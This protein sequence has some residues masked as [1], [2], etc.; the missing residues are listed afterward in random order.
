MAQ[1]KRPPIRVFLFQV[2]QVDIGH[3]PMPPADVT[4]HFGQFPARD[5]LLRYRRFHLFRRGQVGFP[6]LAGSI[7]RFVPH[8]IGERETASDSNGKDAFGCIKRFLQQAE[9]QLL[10]C[11]AYDLR[12]LGPGRLTEASLRQAPEQGRGRLVS[13]PLES[14][15]PCRLEGIH[16]ASLIREGCRG[17]LLHTIR[18][19]P[20]GG[21]ARAQQGQSK[22]DEVASFRMER[23]HF[24]SHSEPLRGVG[25]HPTTPGQAATCRAKRSI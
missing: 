23:F 25:G 14:E 22:N 24:S 10:G 17:Y 2:I 4:I 8:K 7:H 3:P 20:R 9:G 16:G 12:L 1:K 15:R 18:A 6:P 11:E 5:H 21:S 13:G 19:D